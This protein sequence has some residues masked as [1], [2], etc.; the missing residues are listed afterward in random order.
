MHLHLNERIRVLIFSA[1][2]TLFSVA[3][4]FADG[5]VVPAGTTAAAPAAPM[6]A[7]PASLAS[8]AT[9]MLLMFGVVYFLMIRPQQKKMKEQQSMLSQLK[10]GDEV[11]MTSG[12]IGKITGITDK[13]VT[14]EVDESVRVKML[15]SQ[16]STVLKGPIQDLKA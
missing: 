6:A 7:Q 9:P 4:A 11:V 5:P 13:V 16:V 1:L 12:L 10:H 14:L 2:A 3:N 8:M 15:K